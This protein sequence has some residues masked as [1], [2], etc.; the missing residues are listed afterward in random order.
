[1]TDIERRLEA[2]RERKLAHRERLVLEG[3][4]ANTRAALEALER[5]RAPWHIRAM[6]RDSVYDLVHDVIDARLRAAGLEVPE[7]RQRA[8]R[9][10]E[11]R[12]PTGTCE[13]V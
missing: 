7:R 1:M 11:Y 4:L 13:I 5:R 3:K 10:R 6:V 8:R 9:F 2:D 12:G